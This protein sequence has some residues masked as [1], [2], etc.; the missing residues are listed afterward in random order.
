[1]KRTTSTFVERCGLR[2]Y[3]F[4]G[5]LRARNAHITVYDVTTWSWVNLVNPTSIPYVVT[6]VW[7]QPR[8]RR[9]KNEKRL[10]HT[11]CACV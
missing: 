5:A 6:L 3:P 7:G 11:V 4:H 1:M 10:V 9:A 2:D 8:P